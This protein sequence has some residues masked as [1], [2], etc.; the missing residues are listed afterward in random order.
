MWTDFS[1]VC[2]WLMWPDPEPKIAIWRSLPRERYEMGK[3]G[4]T[5]IYCGG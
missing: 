3:D 4:A 2:G 5:T 1:R